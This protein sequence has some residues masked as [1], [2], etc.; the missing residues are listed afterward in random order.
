MP[1]AR[2][3]QGAGVILWF[4]M[5]MLGGSGPPSEVLNETL[6]TIGRMTPL[7]HAVVLL[8]DPWLGWGWNATESAIVIAFGLV[9]AVAAFAV[10]RYPNALAFVARRFVRRAV[11]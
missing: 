6:R 7:K 10:L 1:N 9:S 3:A 8:Q 4:V 2:A 5:M 11:A